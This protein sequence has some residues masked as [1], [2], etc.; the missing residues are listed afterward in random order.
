[1]SAGCIVPR[2]TEKSIQI[3]FGNRIDIVNEMT[4]WL[5]VNNSQQAFNTALPLIGELFD[6]DRALI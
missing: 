5:S 6:L 2:D 3:D 4:H 1:M